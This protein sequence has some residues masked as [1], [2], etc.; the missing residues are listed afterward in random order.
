MAISN[1]KVTVTIN[2]KPINLTITYDVTPIVEKLRPT[3]GDP[4][5]TLEPTDAQLDY[6][7]R[8]LADAR[9][10]RQTDRLQPGITRAT[11]VVRGAIDP[12]AA[13]RHAR[14]A[15]PTSILDDDGIPPDFLLVTHSS[16]DTPLGDA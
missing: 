5:A 12:D 8:L 3:V 4:I 1:G 9:A 10:Q 13:R 15:D 6:E 14:D 2:G 16:P 11:R 7:A